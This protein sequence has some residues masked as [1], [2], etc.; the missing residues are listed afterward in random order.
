[1][2]GSYS[3]C[4]DK[5]TGKLLRPEDLRSMLENDGDV[6]EAIEELYGMVWYLAESLAGEYSGKYG[7]TAYWVEQARENY[8]G[9][10]ESSPGTDGRLSEDDR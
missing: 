5:T 7:E 4:I 6:R 8:L 2:A 1:M 10:L 9:G 3:H